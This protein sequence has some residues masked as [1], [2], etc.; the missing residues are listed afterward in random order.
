MWQSR[1]PKT[2]IIKKTL[3][4]VKLKFS[5]GFNSG[6]APS[7]MTAADVAAMNVAKKITSIFIG[8]WVARFKSPLPASCV[9]INWRFR[10]YVSFYKRICRGHEQL[11]FVV[12]FNGCNYR[13]LEAIDWFLE[14]VSMATK[15]WIFLIFQ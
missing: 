8:I 13:S 15:L 12:L 2:M 1:K 6:Q 4:A 9:E 10:L 5:T 7:W 3:T 11:N 14:F